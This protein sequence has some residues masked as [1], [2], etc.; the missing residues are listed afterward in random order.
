MDIYCIR[1]G[2]DPLIPSVGHEKTTVFFIIALA[3]GLVP[4]IIGVKYGWIFGHY[5]YNP[6]LTPLYW[7]WY[8]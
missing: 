2:F 7:D 1:T 3:F 5:Y 4:E 6:A 8:R